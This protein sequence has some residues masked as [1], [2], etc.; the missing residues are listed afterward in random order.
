MANSRYDNIRYYDNGTFK[1]PSQIKVFDGTSF[2]DLGT[3]ESFSTKKLCVYNDNS[4][5]CATYYRH[6]VNIPKTISIGNGKY[7][8]LRK[9]NGTYLSV[10]TYNSGYM[11]EMVVEVNSTTSLYTAYTRNQGDIINQSYTN[12]VAEVSGNSV[13]LKINTNFSGNRISDGKYVTSTL[14]RYTPYCFTKGEKVRIYM[15]KSSTSS[16]MNI[17]IYNMSGAELCNTNVGVN[18]QW[19]GNPNNHKLG[20][21]TI[22]NSGS[23]SSYGDSKVY[24]FKTTPSSSRSQIFTL[25]FTAQN[26]GV[27]TI[28]SSGSASGYGAAYNTSVYGSSY[29]EYIRQTV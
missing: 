7:L 17:R 24:S 18:T 22:N 3:K 8:D 15:T 1:I 25:D 27:N 12:Y 16:S 13:R 5:L 2:V 20:H 26:S 14:T 28:Y 21:V 4:F 29:T 19:V 9:S 23:T 10:D 11:W 6:D